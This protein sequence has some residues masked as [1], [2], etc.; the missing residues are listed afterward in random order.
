[1]CYVYSTIC[2]GS[3]DP[4]HKITYYIKWV[5][6]SRTYSIVCWSSHDGQK[7]ERPVTHLTSLNIL[8]EVL[9]ARTK[10]ASEKISIEDFEIE[11]PVLL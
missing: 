5:T 1:M 9:K 6:I 2:P 8:V 10:R 3:S 7:S 11:K 4:F